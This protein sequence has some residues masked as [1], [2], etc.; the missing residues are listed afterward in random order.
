M[1]WISVEKKVKKATEKA[2]K[3]RVENPQRATF[4]HFPYI[5]FLHCNTKIS[6]GGNVQ[7]VF[8]FFYIYDSFKTAFKIPTNRW[9][10]IVKNSVFG[11]DLRTKFSS[12]WIDINLRICRKER[13]RKLMKIFEFSWNF[14]EN[15]HFFFSFLIT[16]K[17]PTY[18]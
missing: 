14:H 9:K 8:L 17:I 18:S 12:L 4:S 5:F 11:G 16:W 3:H 15:F 10:K 2:Q 7:D 1:H 13:R 6:W